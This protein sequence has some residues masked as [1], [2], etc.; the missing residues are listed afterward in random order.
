MLSCLFFFA[1]II[2][3]AIGIF[4]DI[5]NIINQVNSQEQI[6]VHLTVKI[7]CFD[8]HTTLPVSTMKGLA[9]IKWIIFPG[10]V[11]LNSMYRASIIP[12]IANFEAEYGTLQIHIWFYVKLW[13]I[14]LHIGSPCMSWE[15]AHEKNAPSVHLDHRR[16]KFSE[17]PNLTHQINLNQIIWKQCIL[18]LC[19]NS[20]NMSNTI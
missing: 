6:I 19:F 20:Q 12:R 16:Q 15:T 3:A 4:E 10:W 7:K 11:C 13:T 5:I 14:S 9:N 1:C 17:N 8:Y 2:F 18:K